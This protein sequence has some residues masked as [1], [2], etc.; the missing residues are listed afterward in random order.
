MTQ[1]KV[2]FRID[3]CLANS[4]AGLDDSARLILLQR[5]LVQA[6]IHLHRLSPAS[7]IE[8]EEGVA[9]WEQRVADLEVSAPCIPFL[10]LKGDALTRLAFKCF[11]KQQSKRL[12]ALKFPLSGSQVI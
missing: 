4:V 6:R 9:L 10:A 2:S 12:P 7:L 3:L 5:A 8:A 1:V 11:E